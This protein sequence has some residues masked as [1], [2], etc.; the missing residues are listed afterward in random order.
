MKQH[1]QSK[2]FVQIVTWNDTLI[3]CAIGQLTIPLLVWSISCLMDLFHL[4]TE[5]LL[6]FLCLFKSTDLAF[7]ASGSIFCCDEGVLEHQ[8]LG[9]AIV[10]SFTSY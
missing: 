10:V 8:V 3:I 4:L 2:G 6:L 9:S 7:K 1:L 5:V